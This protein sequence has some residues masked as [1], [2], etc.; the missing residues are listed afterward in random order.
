[1]DLE[2]TLKYPIRNIFFII[3]GNEKA[4]IDLMNHLNRIFMYFI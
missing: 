4:M 3:K 2:E 1:M